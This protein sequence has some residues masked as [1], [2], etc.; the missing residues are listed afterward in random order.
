MVYF[1][2][3]FVEQTANGDLIVLL[4]LGIGCNCL[5]EGTGEPTDE[6][7]AIISI[8]L[9]IIHHFGCHASWPLNRMPGDEMERTRGVVKV[10]V[11]N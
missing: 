1:V 2:Q 10:R 9:S 3:T 11:E 6:D 8:L 4:A 7:T 5:G